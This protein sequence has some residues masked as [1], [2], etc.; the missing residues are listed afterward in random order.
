MANLSQIRHNCTQSIKAL[1]QAERRKVDDLQTAERDLRQEKNKIKQQQNETT[2]WFNNADTR[3]REYRIASEGRLRKYDVP[4]PSQYTPVQYN[5]TAPLASLEGQ[6]SIHLNQI[7]V[8]FQ[9]IDRDGQKLIKERRKWW[10]F[11]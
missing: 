8:F 2:M 6:V 10:K 3:I 7:N 5:A 11:W 1:R 4:A 9:E